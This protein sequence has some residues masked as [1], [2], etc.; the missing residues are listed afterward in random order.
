[1]PTYTEAVG[2]VDMS[3]LCGEPGEWTHSGAFWDSLGGCK[4]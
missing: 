2:A 4:Q 3:L 1:M